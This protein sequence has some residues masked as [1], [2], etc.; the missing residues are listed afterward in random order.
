M[1]PPTFIPLASYPL[2]TRPYKFWWLSL[3]PAQQLSHPLSLLCAC[4]NHLNL[5]PQTKYPLMIICRFLIISI[6][7][8]S[9][10]K[11]QTFKLPNLSSQHIKSLKKEKK[12]QKNTD[13]DLSACMWCDD[14]LQNVQPL[15]RSVTRTQMECPGLL[16]GAKK[17]KTFRHT[18]D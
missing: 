12:K 14:R 18:S 3:T 5:A 17:A 1:A 13:V 9:D 8:N 6:S 11:L 7:L 16:D 4:P 2:S 15:Y 10:E